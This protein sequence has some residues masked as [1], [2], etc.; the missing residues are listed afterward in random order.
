MTQGDVKVAFKECVANG[1]QDYLCPDFSNLSK[2][3]IL[4]KGIFSGDKSVKLEV[5]KCTGQGCLSDYY[6]N[7][8]VNKL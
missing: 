7:D 2:N 1:F 5:V 3:V 6:M 8:F 4:Q